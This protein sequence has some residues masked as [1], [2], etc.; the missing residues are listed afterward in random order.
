MKAD[1]E[2]TKRKLKKYL[3]EHGYSN[4]ERSNIIEDVSLKSGLHYK[5]QPL[6]NYDDDDVDA[7]QI[8]KD[9]WKEYK[10]FKI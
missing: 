8:V 2:A 10:N 1:E 3:K 9:V 5:R 4:S 7:I 6:G